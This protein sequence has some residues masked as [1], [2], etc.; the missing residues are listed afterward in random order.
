MGT[1]EAWL[2]VLVMS[3]AVLDLLLTILYAKI[4]SRGLSRFGA[5]V[6]SVFVG[7]SIW[8]LL[9]RVAPALGRHGNG[10]LTLAGPL[11]VLLTLALWVAALV[12]GAALLI[13]PHLGDSIAVASGQTPRDFATALYASAASLA[14]GSTSDLAPHSDGMRILYLADA[15]LGTMVVTLVISYV[16][17]IYSGLR[18]RNSL[19]LS[20][21]L[22]SRETGNAEALVAGLGPRG[23]FT[24][25]P[26]IL[27]D[28]AT[29]M[30]SVK[31]AHHFYPM[32]FFFHTGAAE[33]SLVRCMRLALDSVAHLRA[34]L[35]D[36]RY[37]SVIESGPVTQLERATLLL[38]D[39]LSATFLPRAVVRRCPDEGPQPHW[40]EQ[41]RR[42]CRCLAAA[43]IATRGD[44]EAGA[45]AYD[46]ARAQW[47]ARVRRIA[48]Y[49]AH[50]EDDPDVRSAEGGCDDP[51]RAAAR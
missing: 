28:L 41:Y 25:A 16:M 27:V 49:L 51:S 5:G 1:V 3:A 40:R 39:T 19:A 42:A 12:F 4:G 17:P 31:E 37:G 20:L 9:R 6:G 30:V 32:L 7:R 48:V 21:H 43:G 24:A 44:A 45:R 23:D 47:D 35:D 50:E 11:A 36:E 2:G 18:D 33:H 26:S 38:V 29:R 10:V 34:C 13:H 15:L 14:L 46:A 8:W 22:L